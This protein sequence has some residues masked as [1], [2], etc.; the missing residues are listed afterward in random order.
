MVKLRG[1]LP[2]IIGLLCLNINVL[3]Q[4]LLDKRI[5]IDAN[6]QRLSEVLKQISSKGDFYFSYNSSIIARDSL[7]SFSAYNKTIKQVLDQ[8]CGSQYKWQQSNNYV[9]LRKAPITP[10]V[11][12]TSPTPSVEKLYTVTGYVM[13]SETGEKVGNV[14]IYEKQ[15]LVST[16]SDDKGYFKI[17]LKSRYSTASLTISRELFEDTT[18]VIK[19]KFDQQVTIVM[20]PLETSEPVVTISPIEDEL[21][22]TIVVKPPT[23]TLTAQSITKEEINRVE[24]SHWGKFL[25]SAKQNIQSINLKKFMADRTFQVSLT[26]GLSTHGKLSA[27]V[28]NTVSVNVVG[29]Y[30]AGVNGVEIAGAFNINKTDV[31]YVQAAGLLNFTGGSVKGVQLAGMHNHVLG[32]VE[33]VQASGIANFVKGNVTG[34]QLTGIYNHVSK[35][36]KGLQAAGIANFAKGNATGVQISSIYNHVAGSFTGLQASN[37]SNFVY[38]KFTGVQLS[39][40][41]NV[42]Y[43]TLVGVQATNIINFAHKQVSGVQLSVIGNVATRELN[44]AQLG[45]FNYA[46]KLRGFQLGL[47]NV[48]DTSDGYSLGLINIVFK[49]YHK[50]TFSTNESMRFNAAFKTGNSKLYSILLMG[51]DQKK[52]T[53]DS[54]NVFSLGYGLGHEFSLG[55]WFSINPEFTSQY[56]YLGN[57]NSTNVMNKLHLQ[58][59]VKFG[60]YF[61]VFGGPSF[62][63]LYSDQTKTY[64]GWNYPIPPTGYHTFEL[65]SNNVKGW[66]GWNAGISIF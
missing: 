64:S 3:A 1:V 9:I 58:F 31:K 63:M 22:D 30:T 62:T 65:W 28:V 61:S 27:Q 34:A 45:L 39:N 50:I 42:C 20:T 23:D 29:G 43:D 15:R 8:F 66:I 7:I 56:L 21:P 17:K 11:V 46:K 40:I 18:V 51:F 6:N 14:T 54:A 35:D 16:M 2:T 49:G 13:N 60:K 37:I 12:I 19:P 32:N 4:N 55:K 57:Y 47:I 38:R 10:P 48:A 52:T 41:Y 44:G 24:K 36:V 25:L 5:T 53:E 33:I 59:H 26:P